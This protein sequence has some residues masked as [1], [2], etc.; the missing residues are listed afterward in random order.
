MSL[1]QQNTRKHRRLIAGAILAGSASLALVLG[2]ASST[3]QPAVT[4]TAVSWPIYPVNQLGETYGSAAGVPPSQQ[5]DLIKA[6]ATN[7]MVGYISKTALAADSG[8]NVSNPQ[9][10]VQW[11]KTMAARG[12]QALPVYA[13]NGTTVIGS[14]VISPGI[15]IVHSAP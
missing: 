1:I 4:N 11:D 9:Q 8:A 12:K 3:Q 2:N 7:G 6:V 13:Q 5:P 15:A 10:A 14:F